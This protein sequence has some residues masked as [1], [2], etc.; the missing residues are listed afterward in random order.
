LNTFWQEADDFG[1]DIK[2]SHTTLFDND[3][4]HP[5]IFH[6]RQ[7]ESAMVA[8]ILLILTC[9]CAWLTLDAF[10]MESPLGEQP[11]RFWPRAW[12]RGQDHLTLPEQDRLQ[13]LTR[14]SFWSLVGLGWLAWMFLAMTVVFAI[15]TVHAFSA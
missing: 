9:G 14:F 8:W 1:T 15:L 4:G 12:K 7:C 13:H 11:T 2:T 10:R 3:C 6:L 5:P